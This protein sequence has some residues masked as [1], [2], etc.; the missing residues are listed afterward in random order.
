MQ[1]FTAKDFSDLKGKDKTFEVEAFGGTDEEGNVHPSMV[2]E[3]ELLAVETGK[4]IEGYV[5]EDGSTPRTPFT[6]TFSGPDNFPFYDDCYTVRNSKL[7]EI[8]RLHLSPDPVC[9]DPKHP[10]NGVC[11]ETKRLT[12]GFN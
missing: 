10:E 2:V 12:A 4:P 11:E 7:G 9:L 3:I 6:V 8:A 5:P 1:A